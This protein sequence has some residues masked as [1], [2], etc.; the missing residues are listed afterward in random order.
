M[1]QCL[2]I[3]SK[4]T[5]FQIISDSLVISSITF[6]IL[7][8]DQFSRRRKLRLELAHKPSECVFRN[9]SVQSLSN[10]NFTNG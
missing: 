1:V 3:I 6:A 2:K 8:L 4:G 7:M 9:Y 5:F 10:S